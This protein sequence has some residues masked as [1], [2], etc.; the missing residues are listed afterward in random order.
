MQFYY[1]ISLCLE[2]TNKRK[3]EAEPGQHRI[4]DRGSCHWVRWV[5]MLTT[6][7]WLFPTFFSY[8]QPK[9]KNKHAKCRKLKIPHGRLIRTLAHHHHSHHHRFHVDARECHRLWILSRYILCDVFTGIDVKSWILY[10]NLFSVRLF[11]TY[12]AFYR[13]P[14]RFEE[15]RSKAINTETAILVTHIAEMR[16]IIRIESI[17]RWKAQKNFS[18]FYQHLLNLWS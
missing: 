13:F 3:S 17:N 4:N 2:W 6:F 1:F 11:A 7:F 9:K 15:R 10:P 18:F 8:A 14:K 16:R 12:L 5:V